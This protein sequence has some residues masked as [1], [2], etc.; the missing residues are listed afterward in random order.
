MLITFQKFKSIQLYVKHFYFATIY[1]ISVT[2]N[3]TYIRK[4][5]VAITPQAWYEWLNSSIVG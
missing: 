1:V 3:D 4:A 5:M 2:N